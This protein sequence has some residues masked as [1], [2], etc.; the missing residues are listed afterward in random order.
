[1]RKRSAALEKVDEAIGRN[2]RLQRFAKQMSQ[3]ELANSLGIS[4]QQLQKY[5]TGAD[6]VSA[7]R[8]FHASR[9][10]RVSVLRFF[11]GLDVGLPAPE[12]KRTF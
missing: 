8:L 5:E 1:M 4:A 12:P 6:R 7:S 9:L 11:D 3:A 10:L 2:I